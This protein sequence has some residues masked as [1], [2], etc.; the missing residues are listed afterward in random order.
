MPQIV[1]MNIHNFM[2]FIKKILDINADLSSNDNT[3][4]YLLKRLSLRI[5]FRIYQ[6]HANF[7]MTPNKNFAEQ[8]HIKYTK[9][10]IETLILQIMLKS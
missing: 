5:L 10:F 9:A 3:N 1:A 6:K 4:L 2:I 7:K 8:F